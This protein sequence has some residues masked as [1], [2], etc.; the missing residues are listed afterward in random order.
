MNCEIREHKVPSNFA[1]IR[2]SMIAVV[3]AVMITSS[4]A[5]GIVPYCPFAGSCPSRLRR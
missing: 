2:A 4:A 1:R 5:A 3:G